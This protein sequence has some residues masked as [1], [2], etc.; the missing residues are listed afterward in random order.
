[1]APRAHGQPNSAAVS[2]QYRD[3]YL[4]T[5]DNF[6]Q[7][8]ED[9]AAPASWALAP[10]LSSKAPNISCPYDTQSLAKTPA[11]A[12]SCPRHVKSTQSQPPQ[13]QHQLERVF[14]SSCRTGR[15]SACF[16]TKLRQ[17]Q[18]IR[19]NQTRPNDAEHIAHLTIILTILQRAMCLYM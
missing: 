15:L 7:P 19:F 16:V 18:Q 6:S 1:M 5:T 17:P 10:L 13:P 11:R 12:P 3:R 9:P 4:A 14:R 2:H 8:F